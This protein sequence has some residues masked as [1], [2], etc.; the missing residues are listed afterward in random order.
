MSKFND[1]ECLPV[2]EGITYQFKEEDEFV[3]I[4]EDGGDNSCG[5]GVGGLLQSGNGGAVIDIRSIQ[6]PT[7]TNLDNNTKPKRKIDDLFDLLDTTPKVSEE[8]HVNPVSN[9]SNTES[10]PH[11]EIGGN[12]GFLN[13]Q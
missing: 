12:P 10:L 1:H 4:D 8:P 7:V 11:N 2:F 6:T 9:I 3:E 13:F 5:N